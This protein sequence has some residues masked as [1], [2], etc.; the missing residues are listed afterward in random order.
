M[1][2]AQEP[3]NGFGLAVRALMKHIALLRGR[4][5]FKQE[6]PTVGF[7]IA[8]TPQKVGNASS[9]HLAALAS[10]EQPAVDS[11]RTFLLD[12]DGERSA[13]FSLDPH[14]M[15]PATHTVFSAD[16]SRARDPN[17]TESPLSRATEHP[18]QERR[19]ED[20]VARGDP[21]D[22]SVAESGL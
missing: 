11:G 1:E 3:Y 19:S 6:D 13:A 18:A 22:L 4:D 14:S 20:T 16:P 8:H 12:D 7:G 10:K 9:K 5:I 15:N 17:R 2:A 21:H